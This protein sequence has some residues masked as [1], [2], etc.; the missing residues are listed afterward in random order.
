MVSLYALGGLYTT[1]ERAGAKLLPFLI[2]S[3]GVALIRPSLGRL[4]FR[5]STRNM[6]AQE[7]FNRRFL[8][9]GAYLQDGNQIFYLKDRLSNDSQYTYDLSADGLLTV[10]AKIWFTP[11]FGADPGLSAGVEAAIYRFLAPF[12]GELNVPDTRARI[13]DGIVA[14][15][16]RYGLT[17]GENLISLRFSPDGRL[18]IDISGGDVCL[19]YNK[20][21]A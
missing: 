17:L 7:V 13:Q 10:Q 14:I 12:H 16:A 11:Y 8:N 6:A 18:S 20:N 2:E 15:L 5:Y 4:D 21:P 3:W 9:G 1:Q 19:P